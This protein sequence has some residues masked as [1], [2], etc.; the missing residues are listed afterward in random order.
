[1]K[2][3][4]ARVST[5]QQS[6]NGNS[7]IDQENKLREAGAEEVVID[8]FTGTKMD[9]PQFTTLLGRMQAGDTLIVTKLDRFARTAVDGGAIIKQLHDKGITVHILNMGITDDTPMGK[10]MVT[11]LLAFAEFERDMIVERTQTGKDIARA[12]GIRVDGRPK[13]FSIEQ[14]RHAMQLLAEGN[15]YIEVS[16]LTGISK[17]TLIR[18]KLAIRT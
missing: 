2:Y 6:N 12:K 13:K 9:R 17:S 8:S 3:G 1:M 11:M 4:Y 18:E 15:S 14:M 5:L 16:K 7:L 10:L